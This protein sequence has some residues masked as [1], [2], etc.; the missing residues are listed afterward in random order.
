MSDFS[1]TDGIAASG[2]QQLYFPEVHRLIVNHTRV[3]RN[4]NVAHKKK[5]MGFGHRV[6]K[7]G[8]SRVPIMREIGRDLGKRSPG[9]GTRVIDSAAAAANEYR[10]G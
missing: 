3:E 9:D 6:Y 2:K 7:K 1:I 4:G 8:D 5:I 10:A